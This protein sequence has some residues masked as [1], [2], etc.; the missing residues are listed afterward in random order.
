M[1]NRVFR[2]AEKCEFNCKNAAYT[3]R[4]AIHETLIRDHIILGTNNT[5][6][7][8]QP[9]EKELNLT[10]LISNSHKVGATEEAA[11]VE[12]SEAPSSSFQ[13]HSIHDETTPSTP[14]NKFGKKG[15][16]TPRK[17]NEEKIFMKLKS[18]FRP[19]IEYCAVCAVCGRTNSNRG[20]ECT[21]KN[22]FSNSCGK[23]GHFSTVCLKN[24]KKG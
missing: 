7:H 19:L 3:S 24:L 11:K 12:D 9:F 17:L 18:L 23:K 20:Q 4:N 10:A 2:Y 22:A 13:L 8:E 16:S 15:G 14:L 6:S 21:A 1:K 5:T